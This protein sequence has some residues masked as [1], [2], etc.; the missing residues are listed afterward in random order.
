MLDSLQ[1]TDFSACL[2]TVFRV[3]LVD[4][5]TMPLELAAVTELGAAAIPGGRRP[6]ALL[7]LGPAGNRYLLQGTYPL[8]HDALG[9]LDL[10][11]V[12]LGPEGGRMRYEA[13]FN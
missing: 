2:N 5:Q 1:S 12:P 6:F 7:F 9:R 8:Q 13:I 3:P 10:F 11:V 4:A